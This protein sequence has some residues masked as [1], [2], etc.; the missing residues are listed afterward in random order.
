MN[1]LKYLRWDK[2]GVWI[3]GTD[4]DHE[5]E[6][7]WVTGKYQASF[8]GTCF[9]KAQI[10][11]FTDYTVVKTISCNSFLNKLLATIS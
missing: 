9:T 11:P 1:A 10:F 7:K 4:G 6:W 2:K 3:G 5:G 8:I